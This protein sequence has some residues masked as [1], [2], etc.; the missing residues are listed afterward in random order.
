MKRKTKVMIVDDHAVVRMGLAAIVNLEDD[1][2]V[3]G[4]AEDGVSAVRLVREVE[5]DVIVMDLVMP[6]MNGAETAGKIMEAMP[7]TKVLILTT[8]GEAVD[9]VRAI[10]A[11]VS[12]VV[13][14][15]IS[16]ADL[17]KVIRAVAAGERY[18]SPAIEAMLSGDEPAL[19][20]TPRQ[21]EALD[22][23]AR[24]LSNDEIATLLG[25]SKS[26]VKQLLNE[27]YAKMGAA[28]RSEAVAIAI[29][30]LMLKN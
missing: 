29:R 4:E 3:C 24:G 15:D 20:L 1:L 10:V 23:I 21:F 17:L 18:L 9:I 26:R 30:R 8:F 19:R 28:N 22:A 11:G 12:G 14:K 13:T 16:T 27:L 7:S 2:S 5:P 6:G 25:V